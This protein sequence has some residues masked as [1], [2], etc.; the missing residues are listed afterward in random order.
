MSSD[1]DLQEWK[2]ALDETETRSVE[3]ILADL[4]WHQEELSC[5]LGD[6]REAIQALRLDV[7]T[8]ERQLLSVRAAIQRIEKLT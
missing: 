3:S 6:L 8:K 5:A 7:K 4:R 2:A 1:C